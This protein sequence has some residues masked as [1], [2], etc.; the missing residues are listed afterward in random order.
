MPPYSDD[1]E[2]D[3]GEQIRIALSLAP[4]YAGRNLEVPSDALAVPASIGRQG[5]S[6]VI[7]H[8]L[9]RVPDDDGENKDDEGSS[10]DEEEK[11]PALR[12]IKFEFILGKT[13]RLLRCG[14]E[15]EARRS[16]ISLEEAIPITYFPSQAAPENSGESDE[17]PD[18]IGAMAYCKTPTSASSVLCTGTYDGSIHLFKP[19]KD[20]LQPLCEPTRLHGAAVKCID[21]HAHDNA[22]LW[23][24]SGSMDHSLLLS[25]IQDGRIVKRF[26]CTEGHSAAM[27]SLDLYGAKRL[28]ASGDWD[29]GIA[30]WNYSEVIDADSSVADRQASKKSK[31]SETDQQDK[32]TD[33]TDTQIKPLTLIKAHTSNVSG[34]SWGNAEKAKGQAS[35]Y[36]VTASWDHSIKLWDVERRDCLLTL[37]GSKVVSCMDTSYYSTGIVATGHPD[38]SIRLWDARVQDTKESSLNLSD[39]TLRVSHKAWITDLQWSPYNAYHLVSTGHDGTVKGWDIRSPIPLYTVRVVDKSEKCLSL[40]MGDGQ[41]FA[42]GTDCVVKQ[43]CS[44][45]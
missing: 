14:V 7:N 33:A 19:S 21:V 9:G 15:K 45:I 5:L 39:N 44:K 11:D 1:H 43:L 36:L 29:G 37:N 32:T 18:W 16:G 34:I 8:L 42:G 28:L 25:R 6:S 17:L 41:V 23:L 3:V 20:S 12:P 4:E 26:E 22:T 31:T 35:Q 10:D 13:N 40:A 30:I 24:A 27:S 2:E 38:C